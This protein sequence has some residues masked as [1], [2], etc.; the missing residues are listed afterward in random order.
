VPIAGKQT[1]IFDTSALNRL[2]DD[3]DSGA[4]LAG[5]KAAFSIRLTAT[6]IDDVAA[7][8]DA[9]RRRALLDLCKQLLFG[10]EC[11]Q[12]YHWI[13]EQLITQ[14]DS[15]ASL[16]WQELDIRSREYEEE[17]ARQEILDDQ[18]AAEQWEHARAAQQQFQK[19]YDDARPHFERLF[20]AAP[21]KRPASFPDLVAKLKVPGGAF[22]SYAIGLYERAAKNRVDEGAIRTFVDEY[23]PFRALLLAL[24]IAQYERCIRDLR[25]GPSY[26]A[27]SFDL[28]AAVYLPYCDQFVTAEK[29]RRQERCLAEVAREGGLSVKVGSYDNLRGSAV[30]I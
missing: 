21:E 11:I 13:I 5:L 15:A 25:A 29:R 3:K 10:G 24:C 14:A 23:P 19:I 22:W 26:R 6:N 8:P 27:G 1:L 16:G 28:Y 2:A 9:N 17:I 7:T 12:P 18:V 20:Q 4:L 30:L